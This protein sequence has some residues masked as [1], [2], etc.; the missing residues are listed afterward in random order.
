MLTGADKDYE[1]GA[2][3]AIFASDEERERW[4]PAL[5]AALEK[6]LDAFGC[7]AWFDNSIPNGTVVTITKP[8]DCGWYHVR[9]P[10]GD[11][12]AVPCWNLVDAP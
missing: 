6:V 9:L 3:A 2:T 1:I 8:N 11:E 5:L 10:S 7:V 12:V 4:S